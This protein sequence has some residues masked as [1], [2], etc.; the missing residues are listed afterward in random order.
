M[1]VA[2]TKPAALP[3]CVD[4]DGTLVATDT[5]WE[6]A[7]ALLRSQ[8]LR[9]LALPFWLAAG[10]ATLKRRLAEAAPIDVAALPYRAE[11]LAY[12]A[13]AR[14]AGRSVVL[15]TASTRA[16]AQR[17]AAHTNA[18]DA[19]LASDDENL[20]GVHKRDALVARYGARGFEYVG[21]A[22]ADLAVWESAA[23][24]SLVSGS[25]GL[26]AALIARTP[27]AREFAVAPAGLGTWLR[28][29]RVSQW[30]KN[31]LLFLPL[32]ASHRFTELPLIADALLA[33]FAF[34][35]T[36]SAVYV[37]NDLMDLAAD[38]A[39]PVKCA[40]PFATGALSIP[41]GLASIPVLLAGA[42]AFAA[43][44]PAAF[45]GSLALYL[46]AN[47]LYTLWLKRVVLADVALLGGLYALRVVVGGLATGIVVS[48]WLMG[49]SLFFFLSLAF[50]K[51]F[52]ELR[53]L[54]EDGASETPGRGYLPSDAPVLLA[55]GPAC[56]VVAAL[57]LGLY[58][59][60]DLV[61]TLY[62]SP[63]LLW[64]LVPLLIYWSGRIWLLAQRGLLDDDPVL[65]AMRDRGSWLVA[66]FALAVF[67][68][69]AAL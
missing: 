56:A 34:G 50:L 15:V 10:L 54:G 40:R 37:A 6:S 5:L 63:A 42:L 59:Q 1:S 33:F 66:A 36:A 12:A 27:L 68:A 38:R 35:L 67:A 43:A 3:L 19:V 2:Q 26:R 61:R 16:V 65:F 13:E 39:H 58:I 7:L 28:G 47:V 9:A 62:R 49:F 57:V 51:R 45:T 69:A 20:K 23:C 41:A 29:L 52:A 17:V 46:V 48:P 44:L 8:P 55:L 25:R 60:G 18:F 31:A 32:L 4:L 11:V 64:G 14:A 22:R 24:G 21:D 53:R 30:S